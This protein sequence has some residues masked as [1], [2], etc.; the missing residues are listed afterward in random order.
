MGIGIEKKGWN[1]ESAANAVSCI[2]N[3]QSWLLFFFAKLD[4]KA[5]VP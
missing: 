2:S 1:Q 5:S 4:G 3:H